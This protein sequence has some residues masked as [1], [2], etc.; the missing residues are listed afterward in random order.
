MAEVKIS[1]LPPASSA[2]PSD[3]FP[4]VQGGVTK[5]LPI[6]AITGSSTGNSVTSIKAL[7]ATPITGS[8][9][10][11]ASFYEGWAGSSESPKGG[12]IFVFDAAADKALHNG[13]TVY[14]PEALAAW[15]GAQ[16]DIATMLNWTG[17]G[18]GCW[19]RNDLQGFVTPEMAGAVGDGVADDTQSLSQLFTPSSNWLSVKFSGYG[20]YLVSQ[21]IPI[22]KKFDIDFSGATVKEHLDI[23]V[24]IFLCSNFS[25]GA[26]RNAIFIGGEASFSGELSLNKYAI[27][28]MESEKVSVSNV[29]VFG[30]SNAILLDDCDYCIVEKV[31]LL[32]LITSDVKFD[33]FS[34]AVRFSG[35]SNNRAVACGAMQAGGAVYQVMDGKSLSVIGA[36]AYDCWDNGVYISSGM[37]CTVTGGTFSRLLGEG[38]TGVKA[39]GSC[40]VVS[41]NTIENCFNGIQLSGNG[42]TPDPDGANGSGSVAIGN[43]VR[44]TISSGIVVNFQDGLDPRDF[45]ISNNTLTNVATSGGAVAAILLRGGGHSVVNNTIDGFYG[46]YGILSEGTADI[47]RLGIRISNNKTRGSG[48][49]VR[50]TYVADSE[51]LYNEYDGAGDN[52]E[53]RYCNNIRVIGNVGGNINSSASYPSTNL[54]FWGNECELFVFGDHQFG[55]EAQRLSINMGNS[56][57]TVS[58]TQSQSRLLEL[59]GTFTNNRTLTVPKIKKQWI[60]YANVTGGFGVNV[61]T[62]IG[63]PVL[64]AGG[65]RAILEC[66]GT[67]V[68]RVSPDV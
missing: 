62:G 49:G 25:N 67:E 57:L 19:V 52:V 43:A 9:Y 63:A 29:N 6:G 2:N 68:F 44:N 14:A 42:A 33:Y 45:I 55:V 37:D 26:I 1:E 3:V 22:T 50:V 39:R 11:V 59:T 27:K 66:N 30:K 46:A 47:P 5:K 13:V 23:G 28:I 64:V 53:L 18:S 38:S 16:S 51:I 32:G 17:A 48:D 15:S 7:P 31:T 40:H 24:P 12:G 8:V 41:N 61:T 60:I 21:Q 36:W 20:N 65:K 56:S 34:G 58:L 35:G 4:I 54:K 10:S